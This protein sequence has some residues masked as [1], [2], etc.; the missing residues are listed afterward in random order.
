MKVPPIRY[1]F[2]I[3]LFY[4][5]GYY[6]CAVAPRQDSNRTQIVKTATRLI[7]TPYRYGGNSP[8]GFDCSGFTQY[9]YQ[10]AAGIK[11]ARSADQQ[12]KGGKKLALKNC[13]PGDLVFFKNKGRI[14]HVGIIHR[15]SGSDIWMIHASSSRGVVS[16]EITQSPY[17]G[18]RI[19]S[20]KSYN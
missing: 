16:E 10:N 14:D 5:I 3:L 13:K 4:F 20:Y 18:S 19:Y 7:N 12:S 17:W 6:S 8:K 15:I 2:P 1:C 9:V 11:L